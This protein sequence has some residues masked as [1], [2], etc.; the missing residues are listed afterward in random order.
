MQLSDPRL[1][2]QAEDL[3]WSLTQQKPIKQTKPHFSSYVLSPLQHNLYKHEPLLPDSFGSLR[4]L[5]FSHMPFKEIPISIQRPEIVH[6]GTISTYGARSLLIKI[7]LFMALTLYWISQLK[8]FSIKIAIL[9]F[10]FFPFFPAPRLPEDYIGFLD[11]RVFFL[12]F[13]SV[14]LKLILN[15]IALHFINKTELQI[16]FPK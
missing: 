16:K 15:V 3:G 4:D 8:D 12:N 13:S 1:V 7:L 6:K 14:H 11:K 5:S 10:F 9:L 2:K